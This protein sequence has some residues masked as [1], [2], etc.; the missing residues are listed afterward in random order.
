MQ[1]SFVLAIL[2]VAAV[3]DFG[4]QGNVTTSNNGLSLSFRSTKAEMLSGGAFGVLFEGTSLVAV[5]KTLSEDVVTLA[6]FVDP[7]DQDPPTAFASYFESYTTYQNSKNGQNANGPFSFGVQSSD[8]VVAKTFLSLQEVNTTNNV[9]IAT[10][11]LVD[12]NWQLLQTNGP[13]TP[14]ALLSY[15]TL[16]GTF[17]N[18]TPANTNFSIELTGVFSQVLGLLNVAGTP[19]LTP[20]SVEVL[21][22]ITGFP[23]QSPS[24]ALRLN[25]VVG[26][27]QVTFSLSESLT[28]VS[29]NGT[30]ENYVRVNN[31]VVVDGTQ[32]SAN[33]TLVAVKS[34]GSTVADL[35]VQQRYS[36][37]A[38]FTQVS[39]QFPAG[40]N[41]IFF[42]PTAGVGAPPVVT[43]VIA[44][45]TTSSV[46]QFVP[47]FALVF[48]LAALV[49]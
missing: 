4:F 43:S 35:L 21:V 49:L 25:F 30:T 33:L 39:V 40:A 1:I 28:L 42:D 47:F 24:D 46:S 20:L 32:R 11:N 45:S 48:F 26:T 23:Y 38:T 29:G 7:N 36:Q 14:N 12:L 17:P 18:P 27:G 44:A 31:L 22:N 6:F 34:T 3:A 10:V 8:T 13:A 9:T 37:Q 19:L 16:K 5:N 15:V 2:I 41:N